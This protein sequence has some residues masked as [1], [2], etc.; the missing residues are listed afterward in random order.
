MGVSGLTQG[1]WRST[2]VSLDLGSLGASVA[3][4]HLLP[5]SLF[6]LAPLFSPNLLL[7]CGFLTWLRLLMG[8]LPF[9]VAN[10]E[11]FAGSPVAGDS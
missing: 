10:G 4:A 7:F 11:A 3:S 5:V 2:Q 9:S 1:H 8:L 6:Q